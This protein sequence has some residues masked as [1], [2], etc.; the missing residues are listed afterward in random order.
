VYGTS[1]IPTYK[2]RDATLREFE[3]F[4]LEHGGYQVHI[5][6]AAEIYHSSFLKFLHFTLV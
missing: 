4:T 2:G 3:K 1:T 5:L 6:I